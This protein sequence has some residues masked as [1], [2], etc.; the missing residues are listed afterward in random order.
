MGEGSTKPAH[1]DK[2]R[3]QTLSED[4]RKWVGSEAGHPGLAA[5]AGPLEAAVVGQ[6]LAQRGD[7]VVD[8]ALRL[9]LGQQLDHQVLVGCGG[10]SRRRRRYAPPRRSA[11]AFHPA[12]RR[13]RSGSRNRCGRAARQGPATPAWR[14]AGPRCRCRRPLPDHSRHPTTTRYDKENRRLQRPV[15]SPGIAAFGHFLSVSGPPVDHGS[16]KGLGE[17]PNPL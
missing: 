2:G 11:G 1:R 6:P 14:R 12:A 7:E 3:F 15:V 13:R 16:K 10:R 8:G 5:R 4:R 17:S 9:H